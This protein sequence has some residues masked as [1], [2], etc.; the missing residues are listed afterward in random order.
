MQSA[1]VFPEGFP[2]YLRVTDYICVASIAFIFCI[3]F[4]R[5]LL[6]DRTKYPNGPKPPGVLGNYFTIAKSQSYPDQELLSLA[7][8]FGDVCMLWYG[9]NPVMI[10][11]TP[12]VAR[13]LLAQILL[14]ALAC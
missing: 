8:R 9:S 1:M 6:Y 12:K 10:L 3:S 13:E 11:N 5:A 2:S 4:I 7:S 14:L